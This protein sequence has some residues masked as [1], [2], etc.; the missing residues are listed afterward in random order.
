MNQVIASKTVQ[1]DNISTEKDGEEHPGGLLCQS[2][3][4][5]LINHS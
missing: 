5:A 4:V 3:T 2:H 1:D